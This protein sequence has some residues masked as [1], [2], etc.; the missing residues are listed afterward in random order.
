MKSLK[1]L[2]LVLLLS[3][4]ILLFSY[5]EPVYLIRIL[6]G[7][8]TQWGLLH[9]LRIDVVQELETCFVARAPRDD[10]RILRKNRIRFTV[11]DKNIQGK[12]YFLLPASSRNKL[13]GLQAQGRL[14]EVE[15]GILLAWTKGE[16]PASVIPSDV[17]RK[18]L[19]TSSI[20]SYLRRPS[21]P[22]AVQEFRAAK[23][24]LIEFMVNLVSK[25]NLRALVQGL[26]SFQ[27]RYSSTPNCEA[28]GDFIFNFFQT[29]GLHP[30]FEPFDFEGAYS[31]RNIIVEKRGE[32][33]P[34]EILII[35]A[36]YDSTSN[37]PTTLA[38]GADDDAS[39]VAAVMEAARILRPYA[40]DFTVRFIAFSAEEWGLYGSRYYATQA[41]NRGDKIIGVINLDMIAYADAM[42]EDLELFVN[43]DSE[44]LAERFRLSAGSYSGLRVNTIVDASAVYSDHAP[45]WD[46]GY[47]ALLGIE[48]GPLTNP[49]YHQTTDTVDTLNFDFFTDATKAALGTAAEL[50]QPVRAGYPKAPT[51]L[52]AKTYVYI[53]LFNPIRTVYLSWTASPDALGYNIYRSTASHL[54][55]QK[56]NSS[57]V[58]ST[59]FMDK[60]LDADTFYFYV[61]TAVGS[62]GWESNY[63]GEVE[64]E[65]IPVSLGRKISRGSSSLE[66]RGQR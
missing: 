29:I 10:F 18:P 39:G 28:S 57:P 56:V 50:A 61:V 52:A 51:K 3:G 25:D 38:P 14:I 31:S 55:Y 54:N 2:L 27:T 4:G 26:Q 47:S 60:V 12:E 8:S 49:Y 17:D 63:S 43:N 16:A 46:R 21:P 66:R 64:I 1:I 40:F 32:T 48:D 6:K 58:Q 65:P 9:W 59:A 42:P 44:W 45:F 13:A 11:L 53:S 36:H 23:D 41:R 5:S 37:I 20:L 19:P 24:S 62:G 35:C 30:S 7:D 33:D 22:L 34:D 15:N